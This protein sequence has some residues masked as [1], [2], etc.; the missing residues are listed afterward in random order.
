LAG[1]IAG[2]TLTVTAVTGKLAPGTIV[3][4][5]TGTATQG[6]FRILQ[7]LSGVAGGVGTYTTIETGNGTILTTTLTQDTSN[8]ASVQA[9][10]I[11][12][13]YA[14]TAFATFLNN[15]GA[16][17]TVN[18]RIV[19]VGASIQYT[20]KVT[21]QG[22]TYYMYV[23]GDHA[24]L[25]TLGTL[26]LGANAET[27]VERVT[28]KKQWI[29]TSSISEEEMSYADG[30]D[31]Y[32]TTNSYQNPYFPVYPYSDKV[33][34]TYGTYIGATPMVI[35]ITTPGSASFE[36]E[37]VE[38][39]EYIG[40]A[41]Q[42]YITPTHSDA[43]GFELVANASAM[44]PQLRT[45][46]PNASLVSLMD[47]AISIA[48]EALRPVAVAGLRGAAMYGIKGAMSRFGGGAALRAGMGAL[49]LTM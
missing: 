37:V 16:S 13:P 31:S 25:N 44:I 47:K 43:K 4:V 32:A 30:G 42:A 23:S 45:A 14:S 48:D 11:N 19:S 15:T 3:A 39:V 33:P 40:T 8:L 12:A 2:T 9:Y 49:A 21:D 10:T 22:G 28:A 26:D 17:A 29:V 27:Y 18:G 24:N 38:H 34:I 5:L 1:S 6:P 36:L 41:A 20:G 35:Q 46:A 7:Q